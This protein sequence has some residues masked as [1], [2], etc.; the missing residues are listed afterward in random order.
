MPSAQDK[1]WTVGEVLSWTSGY[2]RRKGDEH[3]RLSAEWL[4]ADVLGLSRVEVYTG[5]DRPLSADERSRMHDAVLRRAGGEP[6]QYVTGEMAFRHIVLRCERDVLIPRPE[7]EVLVDVAL[8]GVD[9]AQAAGH[10]GL[11]LEVGCGTGCISCSIASERPGTQVVATDVSPAAVSLATR[12]RD[13]LN[14]AFELEIVECDLASGVDDRL[15][16]CFDVLV[17]NPPYIPSEVVPVLPSEV[18]SWEPALALD[19]GV[20]GLDVFRRL[21]ELAPRALRPGGLLCCEL[22]E[23][24]VSVAAELCRAQGGWS[25]VE[26]RQDLTR[27]PRVLVAVREGSL[28]EGGIMAR[29]SKLMAVDQDSPGRQLVKTCARLLLDGGVLVMPT[30]SVYGI[31]CAAMPRNPGHERIFQIKRRERSQTLPWLVADPIALD[32]FGEDVPV[33]AHE[34]A[35]RF[36]PGALTLV[37]RASRLVGEEYV[38]EGK[39]G[40]LGTIALRCPDSNL[41][42]EIVRELGI[43]L[44]TTSAN[45]HGAPSA[46]SGSAV[47]ERLVEMADLILD[48]GPAPIA[49]ASTIVDCTGEAPRVLREGAIPAS[50]VLQLARHAQS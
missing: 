35:R 4:V 17:S 21:L 38:L 13:A 15:M 31:G 25:L 1:T 19:G 46:T 42:R 27:R 16:G 44:A 49:I 40:G 43:P 37:V 12:N 7:T 34:L 50:E 6:L 5:F 29:P 3:P 33:W 32:V 22:F 45:T 18:T 10:A 2:L 23:T 48:G 24:N 39:D 28:E 8:E 20:D 26:V 9:R 47:E 36:W 14:L 41:V 30:D 11:V